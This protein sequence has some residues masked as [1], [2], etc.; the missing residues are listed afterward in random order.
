MTLVGDTA[1]TGA[2][3]GVDSWADALEPFVG[4]RFRVHE[5]TVNYRTPT[6]IMG[7]AND[8]LATIDPEATP[9]MA[10]RESGVPVEFLPAGTDPATLPFEGEGLVQI[11]DTDNVGQVKGLEFDHVVVVE[12]TEITEGSPQGW[13][14]LYVAITR[15][16]QT[17]TV[18]GA[19]PDVGEGRGEE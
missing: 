6:E 12:P 15:A 13:Q 5:L 3:A 14:D 8:I 11:I 19:L 9:A 1:Q 18:I 16:T 2:P 4:G 17:L 7:T 10:I